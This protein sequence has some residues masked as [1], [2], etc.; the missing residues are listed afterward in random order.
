MAQ[1]ILRASE[2]YGTP[3]FKAMRD[4][5]IAQ[6][7]SWA[8]VRAVKWGCLWCRGMGAAGRLPVKRHVLYRTSPTQNHHA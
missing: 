8:Q 3:A 4:R 5:C 6:D 7:L 1:T 2:V